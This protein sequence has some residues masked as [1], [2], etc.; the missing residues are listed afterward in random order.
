MK[1]SKEEFRKIVLNETRNVLYD[2]LLKEDA[3]SDGQKVAREYLRSYGL[4]E[5]GAFFR[6]ESLKSIKIPSSVRRFGN[7]LFYDCTNLQEIYFEDR[8][9]CGNFMGTNRNEYKFCVNYPVKIYLKINGQYVDVL[10]NLK[11]KN[12]GSSSDNISNDDNI[13]KKLSEKKLFIIN[14]NFINQNNMKMR[15]INFKL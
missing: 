10:Q 5:E 2:L 8:N 9:S 7:E 4:D 1:V 11:N 15:N 12:V 3:E 13:N 14:K 6:C